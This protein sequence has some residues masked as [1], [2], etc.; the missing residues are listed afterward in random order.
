MSATVV[1]V[2][3]VPD[4]E[5]DNSLTDDF[6]LNRESVDKILDETNEHAVEAAVQLNDVLEI[7]HEIIALTMGPASAVEA[8]RRAMAMGADR[9]IHICDDALVGSD[10]IQTAWVLANALGH[11]AD[12]EL[13]IC[14]DQS[15]DA[16]A[17]TV[18]AIIAEYLGIPA[19]TS[20]NSLTVEAD[21]TLSAERA[22]DGFTYQLTADMPALVSVTETMNEPRFPSFKGIMA[23]KKKEVTEWSLADIGVL[24]NQVG[25]AGA[26]TVVVNTTERPV[27]Q[28]GEVFADNGDGAQ[29]IMDY[30]VSEKLV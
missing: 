1:L 18:P 16:G 13:V 22:T 27:K 7:P 8:L 28:Q 15:S 20:V 5:T 9:G 24:P 2:K 14:G 30:L 10:V 11:I 19:L 23:A 3:Q 29:R 4:Y 6:R 12:T 25:Q 21:G 26:G 17:G